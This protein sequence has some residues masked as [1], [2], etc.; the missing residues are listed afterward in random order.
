MTLGFIQGETIQEGKLFKGGHNQGGTLIKG[1]IIQG[2]IEQKKVLTGDTI[3]E[4][5]LFKGGH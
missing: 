2:T 3:Q 5:T 4:G 1:E